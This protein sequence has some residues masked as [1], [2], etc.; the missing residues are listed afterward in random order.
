MPVQSSSLNQPPVQSQS[1]R[2][3]GLSQFLKG[4]QIQLQRLLH[5]AGHRE[6][7]PGRVDVGNFV[8]HPHRNRQGTVNFTGAREAAVRSRP[9]KGSTGSLLRQPSACGGEAGG[10]TRDEVAPRQQLG[11]RDGF[12]AHPRVH[13]HCHKEQEGSH[14]VEVQARRIAKGNLGRHP[15]RARGQYQ[16]GQQAHHERQHIGLAIPA[17]RH[18]TCDPAQLPCQQNHQ[19]QTNDGMH[20]PEPSTFGF[21]NQE[22]SETGQDFEEHG[23]QQQPIHHARMHAGKS[24]PLSG[25]GVAGMECGKMHQVGRPRLPRNRNLSCDG[26]GRSPGGKRKMGFMAC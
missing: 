21:A 18:A 8:E 1:G 3:C 17:G 6:S 4:F 10:S 26:L 12:V 2:C 22:G 25:H 23:G 5:A 9:L 13:D 11:P 16:Q 24:G 20:G 14:D 19:R 15:D 7:E